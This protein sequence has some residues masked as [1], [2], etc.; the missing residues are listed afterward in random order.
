MKLG[1]NAYRPVRE[2]LDSAANDKPLDAVAD[3][4][5]DGANEE[6]DGGGETV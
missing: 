6:D 4:V 5:F 2:G 3:E 1:L